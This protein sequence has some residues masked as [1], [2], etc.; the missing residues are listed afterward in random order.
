MSW[1]VISPDLTKND[2]TKGGPG[3][4]PISRDVSGAEVYCTIFAIAEST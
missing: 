3:G 1:E 2:P 4:E